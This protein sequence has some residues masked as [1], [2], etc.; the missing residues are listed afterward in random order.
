MTMNSKW[1]NMILVLCIG[2]AMLAVSC[3]KTPQ[4]G[5]PPA[6]FVLYGLLHFAITLAGCLCSCAQCQS[7]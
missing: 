6:F 4:A 2:M 1:K 3:T 5:F 7:V